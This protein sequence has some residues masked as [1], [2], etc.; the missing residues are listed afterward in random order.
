MYTSCNALLWATARRITIQYLF[1][2]NLLW[3]EESLGWF[4]SLPQGLHHLFFLLLKKNE[5]Q[6][7]IISIID[8]YTF[9][10]KE[11]NIDGNYE[12]IYT[13]STKNKH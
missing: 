11:E 7:I 6:N 3:K 8:L 10:T 12:E 9:Y 1:K 2:K 4:A 5:L 13:K